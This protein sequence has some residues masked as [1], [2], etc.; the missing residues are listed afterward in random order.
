MRQTG[1]EIRFGG[2]GAQPS[3]TS[4]S[5]SSCTGSASVSVGPAGTLRVVAA[6]GTSGPIIATT[7]VSSRSAADYGIRAGASGGVGITD[8]R[9]YSIRLARSLDLRKAADRDLFRRTNA[10]VVLGWTRTVPSPDV[11]TT[12]AVG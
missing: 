12:P 4:T 6:E 11:V 7:T 10:A 5:A 1:C 8:Y 2:P 9:F 3:M